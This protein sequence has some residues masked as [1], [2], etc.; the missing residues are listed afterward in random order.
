VATDARDFPFNIEDV[1]NLLRLKVRRPSGNGVYVDCPICGDRRGKMR[2]D[3]GN[4]F[5]RC[6]YCG[7][8]GG[9]LALYAKV[10]GISKSDAYGEICETLGAAAAGRT[11]CRLNVPNQPP[12]CP[13][14]R[15]PP[16]S[17]STRP[18]H[19]S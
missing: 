4:N 5:W 18:F 7:E 1:S 12:Q 14:H 9:M 16:F 6:N 10:H 19:F 17:R 8:S 11:M 2:L 13:S 3:Y 15:S